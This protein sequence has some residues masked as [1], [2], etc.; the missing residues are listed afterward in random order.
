[1]H[2]TSTCSS[3]HTM[4]MR[5]VHNQKRIETLA[6]F[7]QLRQRGAVPVH[8]ENAFNDDDFS[9]VARVRSEGVF[10]VIQIE[11]RKDLM[12]PFG[13]PERLARPFRIVIID[14]AHDNAFSLLVLR[15]AD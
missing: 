6:E 12:R 13:F 10:E 11:M 8:A 9:T 7:Q 4:G 2:Q 15:G 14:F 1:M 3:F 5:L